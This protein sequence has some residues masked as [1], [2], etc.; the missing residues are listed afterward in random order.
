MKITK[1]TYN[2]RHTTPSDGNKKFENWAPEVGVEV[3]GDE[4]NPQ[5]A[6]ALVREV[7]SVLLEEVMADVGHFKIHG[8]ERVQ[9]L[10]K[11]IRDI[12][13]DGGYQLPTSTPVTLL[14]PF[15]PP[16]VV[17]ANFPQEDLDRPPVSSYEME[18]DPEDFL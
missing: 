11:T 16:K 9:V 8:A 7:V 13:P 4:L 15:A 17:A 12:L 3:S 18:I 14:N 2:L 5:V 10:P 6:G 1:I